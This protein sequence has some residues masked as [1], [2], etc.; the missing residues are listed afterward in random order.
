MTY[1]DETI[2]AAR[3][4]EQAKQMHNINNSVTIDGIAYTF[5]E[6]EFPPGFSM[7]VPESI[8]ELAPELAR[9]KYPHE[10][11]PQI[12]ISNEDATVNFAFN[13]I[14]RGAESLEKR[15]ASYRSLIKR[16]HPSDV[17]FSSEIY[18]LHNGLEI[19]SFDYCSTAIDI[20]IYNINFFADL[21]DNELLGVFNCPIDSKANWELLVREMIL[22]IKA[23][24]WRQ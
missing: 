22:T 9:I 17:F 20:D 1:G 24:G 5:A 18:K 7:V 10:N 16:L 4:A 21:P 3:V 11:R 19:A 13:Y 23:N 6:R 15:L 8:E 12:I 2:I 14:G